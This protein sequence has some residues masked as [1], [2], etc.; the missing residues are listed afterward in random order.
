MLPRPLRHL[1]LHLAV[2]VAALAAHLKVGSLNCFLFFDPAIDHHGKVDNAMVG[3]YRTTGGTFAGS[4]RINRQRDV[5]NSCSLLQM[6]G[7][8][9]RFAYSGG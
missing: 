1:A 4:G 2:A 8:A 7:V 5:A 3:D 6:Q 9:G